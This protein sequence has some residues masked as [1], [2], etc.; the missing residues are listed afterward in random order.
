MRL[1]KICRS[2]NIVHEDTVRNVLPLLQDRWFRYNARGR[3][4]AD[5][6]DDA[7]KILQDELDLDRKAI[8][9]TVKDISSNMEYV[10]WLF[11]ML[12]K[13]IAARPYTDLFDL[14]SE[15]SRLKN[16]FKKYDVVKNSPRFLEHGHRQISMYRSI[17]DFRRSVESFISGTPKYS[18]L[19]LGDNRVVLEKGIFKVVELAVYEDACHVI[20]DTAWCVKGS[21][22]W[23]EYDPPF[24]MVMRD[25]K[26]HALIH[27]D[28]TGDTFKSEIKDV[29]DDIYAHYDDAMYDIVNSVIEIFNGDYGYDNLGRDFIWFFRYAYV[30]RGR[31]SR[32]MDAMMDAKVVK[33]FLEDP[34]LA[35]IAELLASILRH[36]VMEG[37]NEAEMEGDIEHLI[38]ELE[39]SYDYQFSPTLEKLVSDIESM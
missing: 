21:D 26:K 16:V 14:L 9:D 32:Y 15:L 6:P 18:Q 1:D 37:G 36:Y 10:S 22:Y 30:K 20:R 13:M 38:S 7:K 8:E 17:D 34:D 2:L 31:H 35:K 25:G 11:A 24:Y 12:G 3:T 19:E 23:Q 29:H 4:Y 28:N 27:F 33:S 39:D 5:L